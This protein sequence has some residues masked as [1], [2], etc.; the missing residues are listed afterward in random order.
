MRVYI[1]YPHSAFRSARFSSRF[2]L[3]S[4]ATTPPAVQN[5]QIMS[6]NSRKTREK[7]TKRKKRGERDE[8]PAS[9]KRRVAA[10]PMPEAAP[11]MI[12]VLPP[13]CYTATKQPVREAYPSQVA[14]G[15]IERRRKG[16][17]IASSWR[18]ACDLTTTMPEPRAAC[19]SAC[20]QSWVRAGW[21]GV[22]GE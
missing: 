13:R 4:T 19:R 15:P 1:T 21:Q 20:S 7:H 11:V 12:V 16:L 8:P 14:G 10:K 22:S 2:G 6:K 18:F 5:P 17:S 3:R 9:R